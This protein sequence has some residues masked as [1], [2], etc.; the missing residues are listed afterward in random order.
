LL[1]IQN[2]TNIE[3]SELKWFASQA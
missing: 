1:D 3:A 2:S